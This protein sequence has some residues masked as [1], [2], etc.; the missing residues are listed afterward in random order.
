MLPTASDTR[1]EN[2]R[3]RCPRRGAPWTLWA[4]WA[5]CVGVLALFG[6]WP[7]PDVNEA[8]YLL[9]AKH[10]WQPDFLANDV[11]LQS[12]D[13]HHVFFWSIGWL[14]RFGDNL[15]VCWIG[16]FLGWGALAAGWLAL[17]HAAWR[18]APSSLAD[19]SQ[20]ASPSRFRRNAW[21]VL[22]PPL[23]LANFVWLQNQTQMAGE[24][25][26]GGVEG[27]VFA[28]ACV[29]L[30][31]ANL[32][33]DRWN[34]CG[35]WLGVGCLF[36]VLVGGWAAVAAAWTWV[37]IGP[38]SPKRWIVGAVLG[39]GIA[40]AAVVPNLGL[41]AGSSPEDVRFARRAIAYYRLHHHLDF[42]QFQ[43]W[44]KTRNAI[45]A[46]VAM[47][48]AAGI[49]WQA[50]RGVAGTRRWVRLQLL[51]SGNFL[52]VAAGLAV[53]FGLPYESDAQASLLRFY[54]FRLNDVVLP[55]AAL[56]TV[57][58]LAGVWGPKI[59]ARCPLVRLPGVAESPVVA[60]RAAKD[61]A[62]G[63]SRSPSFGSRAATLALAICGTAALVD[64]ESQW[65]KTN[66][67][68]S[69]K[70]PSAAERGK[71]PPAAD[72]HHLF[73][74]ACLWIK[75]NTPAGAQWLIPRSGYVF[76]W[77][78]ERPD[79]ANWKDMPQ[80]AA[81]QALWWRRMD[82]LYQYDPKTH[83]FARNLDDVGGEE[84]ASL[85]RGMG[86]EFI[87]IEADVE[88]PLPR[89]Y[90]QVDPSGAGFAVYDLRTAAAGPPAAGVSEENKSKAEGKES[91]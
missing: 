10:Y 9:K 82:A 15:T 5:L 28:W 22:G 34:R 65:M 45:L 53:T 59:A 73:R 14:F 85:A 30:A 55:L 33:R 54:W 79:V 90:R 71:I 46:G 37:W 43:P 58:R 4:A 6:G 75:A 64:Q 74:E 72:R 11:F 84:I 83:K 50:R 51:L 81:G 36:H 12:K 24:W 18:P 25:V 35:I 47:L 57:C 31:L 89:I 49:A 87:L 76:K 19:S 27:K 80:D 78:A 48:A 8:Y 17:F 69:F 60:A 70:E 39:G 2:A 44:F 66:A 16:R 23:L 91:P 41:D 67:P 88:W 63:T 52:L 29:W 21:A 62:T 13:A 42:R 1:A 7:P 77:Y 26:V 56:F 32:L 86:A 38:K 40:C 20:T 61:A 68:R 3:P